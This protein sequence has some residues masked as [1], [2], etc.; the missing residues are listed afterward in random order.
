VTAIEIA[1]KGLSTAPPA[2]RA[3]K[4]PESASSNGCDLNE[5]LCP[6]SD[7]RAA[8]AR[9]SSL[10]RERDDLIEQQAVLS[11]EFDHRLLNNLQMVSSLLSMQSRVSSN[12]E[13]VSA[14]TL[15]ASRVAT[16]GRIHAHLHSNDGA[17]SVAFKYFIEELGRDISPMLAVD[18]GA[19]KS[20]VVASV[21]LELP[22]TIAIPLGFI[23]S[24]LITN[25]LKYG[26][27]FIAVRLKKDPRKGFALSVENG[28]P[29]LP[30]DFDLAASKR[31]G[32]RIIQSFLAKIDGKLLIA[33]G[34]GGKG[35]RFT[36]L[37]AAS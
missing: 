2:W 16:I 21:K 14:L 32:M 30:A 34:A 4:L 6:V 19:A 20:I 12:A 26:E 22:T 9:E 18:E 24:E 36:V 37:F 13:T 7:L 27:G 23:V 5:G 1:E 33:Q 35:A 15:A 29:A 31:L 28:G 25:A 10:L 17:Q 8:L 11:R 3:I